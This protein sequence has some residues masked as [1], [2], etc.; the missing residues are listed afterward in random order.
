[1]TKETGELRKIKIEDDVDRIELFG[2][3]DSNLNLIQ[4]STGVEIFQR[5]DSLLLKGEKLDLA[6]EI[7]KEL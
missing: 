7:L 4:E 1:M 6:E 5:D 2:N 3:L